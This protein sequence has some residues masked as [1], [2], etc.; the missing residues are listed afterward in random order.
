MHI[1][2]H[3]RVHLLAIIE[4]QVYFIFCKEKLYNAFQDTKQLYILISH[5]QIHCIFDTTNFII[6]LECN[7]R[8]DVILP[9]HVMST[10]SILLAKG[11]KL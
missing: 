3:S 2:G 11:S 7:C 1:M 10:I 6:T 8:I 5:Y 4:R 9:C